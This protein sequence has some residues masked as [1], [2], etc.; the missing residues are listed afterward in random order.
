[1]EKKSQME[2]LLSSELME[3]EAGACMQGTCICENG[4]AGE[5][6]VINLEDPSRLQPV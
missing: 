2:I 1:M 3:V 5:T 4:G 6:I